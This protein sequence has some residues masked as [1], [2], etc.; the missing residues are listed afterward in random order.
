M[1]KHKI[2]SV[3]LNPE[4]QEFVAS[5][6]DAIYNKT[7]SRWIDEQMDKWLNSEVKKIKPENWFNK[8]SNHKLT[9]RG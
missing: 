7:F 4:K 8:L 1:I 6:L 9:K 2:F 3:S 5:R